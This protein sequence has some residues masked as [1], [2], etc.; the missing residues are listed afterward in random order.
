MKNIL[1]ATDFSF[2]AYNA[3]FHASKLLDD[4]PCRFYLLH[5]YEGTNAEDG[6]QS[7]PVEA[8]S[9]DAL[10]QTYHRIQRDEPNPH[11]IFETISRP[12]NLVEV[13]AKTIQDKGIDLVV[14]GNS[15][16]SEIR[17]IFLGSNVLRAIGG[18]KQC[19]ILTIPKE[20][21]F[22]P[23]KSIAFVTDYNSDYE[24]RLLQPL[25]WIAHKF[26]SKI[27]ILH[28][29]ENA[30]FTERQH[31]NRGALLDYLS[32]IDHTM[33]WV[34]L[35]KSK[36]TAIQDFLHEMQI[37]MLVMV[38]YHYSFLETIGREPVVKRMAFDLDIPF[39]VIPYLH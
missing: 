19:P 22:A 23:P 5:V 13:I 36:A 25:Y 26:Q 6:L 21:E 27:R 1:I 8:R 2:N 14:M 15:G 34:P 16:C 20:I 31:R 38:N 12:G 9:Q 28:I 35:F 29:N 30:D 11:R 39:L 10:R 24:L 17:A 37:D 4:S 18:I 33:N 3:L 7:E 32:D